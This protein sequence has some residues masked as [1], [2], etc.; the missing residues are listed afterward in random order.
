[1][2]LPEKS[3]LVGTEG[4]HKPT[5]ALC[6]S[7]RFMTATVIRNSS[8]FRNGKSRLS[9]VV[10]R[11]HLIDCWLHF[12]IRL[13]HLQLLKQSEA[14][15]FVTFNLQ[16]TDYFAVK[17][18]FKYFLKW[19][20]LSTFRCLGDWIGL[21]KVYNDYWSMKQI[22]FWFFLSITVT[23][24]WPWFRGNNIAWNLFSN[25]KETLFV[26]LLLY[27]ILRVPIMPISTRWDLL[28]TL[29]ST[30]L[31]KSIGLCMF[32]TIYTQNIPRNI[33]MA[34]LRGCLATSGRDD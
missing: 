17:T 13:K 12:A 10:S 18:L 8:V 28:W 16:I 30:S 2:K 9:S 15:Q 1:M 29:Q 24:L 19:Q 14:L 26:L 20:H 6:M 27:S 23:K 34:S 33:L 3:Y 4:P 22:W 21:Y 5:W 32:S 11:S 25:Y 7:S 31:C